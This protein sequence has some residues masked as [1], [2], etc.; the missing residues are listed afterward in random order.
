MAGGWWGIGADVG[1]GWVSAADK[2]GSTY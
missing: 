2:K 1:I